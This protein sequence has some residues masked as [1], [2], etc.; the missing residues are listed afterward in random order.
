[1][2]IFVGFLYFISHFFKSSLKDGYAW[3][4][5]VD[6]YVDYT[7]K[8]TITDHQLTIMGWQDVST[9]EKIRYSVVKQSWLK[10]PVY[11]DTHEIKGPFTK[12]VPFQHTFCNLPNGDGY[13][14]EIYNFGSMANGELSIKS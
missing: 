6:S 2:T 3:G 8:M 9:G 14:I 5:G 10:F 1:M 11:F 13:K 7:E 12:E 4:L